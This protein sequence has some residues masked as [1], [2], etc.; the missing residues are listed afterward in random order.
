MA[1][2]LFFNKNK[3][4]MKKIALIFCLTFCFSSFAQIKVG[5]SVGLNQGSVY[6]IENSIG[7]QVINEL[8]PDVSFGVRAEKS[9]HKLNF[10][11]AW[12]SNFHRKI[13]GAADRG[14]IPLTGVKFDIFNNSLM[15]NKNIY[16]GLRLGG[17]FNYSFVPKINNIYSNYYNLTVAKNKYDLGIIT[18][19]NYNYKNVLL[20][21]NY[22]Y[23]FFTSQINKKNIINRQI[24]EPIPFMQ[25]QLAYLFSIKTP[26]K[27]KK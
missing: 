16:S 15:I 3:N 5:P 13:M 2:T 7:F 24:L 9:I 19:L 10:D 21:F 14:F 17:G 1:N 18:S 12:Q 23:S 27:Q 6:A 22:C 8:K 4:G 26:D 25:L 20:D 11:L